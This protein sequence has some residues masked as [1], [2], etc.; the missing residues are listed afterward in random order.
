MPMATKCMHNGKECG[1]GEALRLRDAARKQGDEA[2]KFTCLACENEVRPHK[3][4]S[5]GQAAH[6]EH[7]DRNRGCDLSHKLPD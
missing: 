3:K 5:N 4:G 1:I 6:F 2:P 7:H